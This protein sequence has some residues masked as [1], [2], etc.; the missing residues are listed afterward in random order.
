MSII[1]NIGDLFV[2]CDWFWLQ[3]DEE[4]CIVL[5]YV[6][7]MIGSN[8]WWDDVVFFSFVCELDIF[9]VDEIIMYVNLFG[10][11]VD[12]GVVIM[13]VFVWNKVKVMV[14]VDGFVVFVVMIV[15]FG[16]DEIVMGVGLCL[17][18]YDVWLIVWGQVFV[19]Q[20]VV[21]CFD[22][23]LQIFVGLYVQCVG[24]DVEQWW[25]VMEVE[26][27]YM[28][29]EVVEVG[30]VDCVV[31]LYME[32]EEDVEVEVVCNVIFICDVVCV[33]GWQYFGCEVVFVLF[34]FVCEQFVV[35]FKF[36]SLFEL[37]DFN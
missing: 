25:V 9:D 20:K 17:M 36:L 1:L 13:N 22:K 2:G 5:F 8:E 27:W 11:I 14:F 18:I 7:G 33:F 24:G 29:E 19:L 3:Y 32:D 16:V 30:F 6:Y 26:I 4:I 28:V 23:L 12:D 15:I 31:V 21:E 35:W 10:G 34:I 37:G